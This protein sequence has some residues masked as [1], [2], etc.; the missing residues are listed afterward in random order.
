MNGSGGRILGLTESTDNTERAAT[1]LMLTL[2]GGLAER[3]ERAE[4]LWFMILGSG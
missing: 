4:Y 1:T 3:A 2:T